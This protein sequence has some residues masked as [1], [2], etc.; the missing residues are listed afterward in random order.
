[1]TRIKELKNK[2]ILTMLYACIL[3]LFWSLHIPCLFQHFLHISC[4]GCGM[5]HA[6]FC[7]LKLDLKN[8]F[9]SHPMFW[10]MPILYVYF[11]LDFHTLKRKVIHYVIL[12]LI[13]LG[14][15]INWVAKFC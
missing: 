9:L 7:A 2:L 11:L 6:M 1:M 15:C 10:S 4:P 14:F 3:I 12:G 8:A 13:G 5:S